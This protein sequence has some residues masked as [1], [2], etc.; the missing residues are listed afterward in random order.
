MGVF[1]NGTPILCPIYNDLP[2][3][4][5]FYDDIKVYDMATSLSWADS[6]IMSGASGSARFSVSGNPNGPSF[7]VV[8]GQLLML[9]DIPILRMSG[10]IR[11]LSIDDGNGSASVYAYRT[12]SSNSGIRL[13][14]VGSPDKKFDVTSSLNGSFTN[15]KKGD[16]VYIQGIC[17]IKNRLYN[18]PHITFTAAY[19]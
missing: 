17:S 7:S 8:G 13:G 18:E 11:A 1:Y 14:G 12:G 9:R 2:L 3:N 4:R 19:T 6:L 5:V 15:L 16:K 10:T